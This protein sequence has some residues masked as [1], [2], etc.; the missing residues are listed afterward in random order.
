MTQ[1]T[2]ALRAAGF[3]LYTYKSGDP[4]D[5]AQ[6]NL[7]GRTHYAEDGTLRYFHARIVSSHA[8]QEG[9]LFYLIESASLD[10]DNTRRGFRFVI[11]DVDGT[12]LERPTLENTFRTSEQ[13]RKAMY[14]WL[15]TFDTRAHYAGMLQRLADRAARQSAD[16]AAAARQLQEI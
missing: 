13:A 5:N 7:E 1:L 10:P 8:L 2:D 4:K 15:D 6:R 3:T 16:Y 9:A 11:F 14:K 12:V